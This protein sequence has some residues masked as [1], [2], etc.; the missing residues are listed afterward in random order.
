M[1]VIT[2]RLRGLLFVLT[3]SS[4]VSSPSFG[5]LGDKVASIDLLATKTKLT[6]KPPVPYKNYT[7]YELS[8][9]TL[10]IREY[11]DK[12]GKIFAVAWDALSHPDLSLLLGTYFDDFSVSVTHGGRPYGRPSQSE[13]RGE[14]VTVIKWGHMRAAHGKAYLHSDLPSDLKPEAIE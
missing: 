12:D 8:D 9:G 7:V 6:K 5:Q 11:A 1:Q 14:H 13:V 10:T 2:H 3:M 4:F